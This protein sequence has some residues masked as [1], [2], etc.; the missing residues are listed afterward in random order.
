MKK[1]V[2]KMQV[3]HRIIETLKLLDEESILKLY[4]FALAFKNKKH[5][6]KSNR[7]RVSIA[8][9]KKC[10]NILSSINGSLNDDIRM[11]REERV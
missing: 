8:N 2:N 7:N 5:L 3:Q 6:V 9:L 11:G 10:Q 1:G 4:D